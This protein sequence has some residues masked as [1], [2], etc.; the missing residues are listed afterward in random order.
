MPLF[1]AKDLSYLIS[2]SIGASYRVVSSVQKF[3]FTSGDFYGI[4]HKKMFVTTGCRSGLY[5]A[6]GRCLPHALLDRPVWACHM[7]GRGHAVLQ[8]VGGYECHTK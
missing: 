8:V 6:R 2:V 5:L 3:V 4:I 7:A 1:R